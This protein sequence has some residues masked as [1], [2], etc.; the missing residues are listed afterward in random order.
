MWVSIEKKNEQIVLVLVLESKS[1]Q[2]RGFGEGNG[3]EEKGGEIWGEGGNSSRL[4]VRF[5]LPTEK[6]VG[7]AVESAKEKY[8]TEYGLT[9][10]TTWWHISHPP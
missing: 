2:W 6:S 7:I 3:G 4:F 9:T 5:F 10:S 8:A 1:E